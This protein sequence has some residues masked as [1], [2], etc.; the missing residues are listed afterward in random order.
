MVRRLRR[1]AD[2]RRGASPCRRIRPA[3]ARYA[4]Q[5]QADSDDGPKLAVI[6][7]VKA[8]T[9]PREG[10]RAALSWWRCRE[11]NPGPSPPCQGFSE[12]SSLCLYSAPP[13]T[14][15]SRC[16]GPS[17]CMIS[18]PGPRDQVRLASLLTDAGYR[19][20]GAPGP[21]DPLPA[22]GGESV[23]SALCVGAYWFP[24][25]DYRD[26]V[27]F[28]GSLPLPQRTKSKPFTPLGTLV[29]PY[30]FNATGRANHPGSLT[31]TGGRRSCSRWGRW[32]HRGRAPVPAG[33]S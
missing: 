21:T 6:P 24:T 14:R 3:V 28:L 1:Y 12:R 8:E 9:A 7:I 17:R 19:V 10:R 30:Y 23:V 31:R 33:R 27:G 25:N 2:R 18:P 5:A 26:D 16:D 13:I 20:E 11:S 29:V 22:S 4:N 15:A 32:R